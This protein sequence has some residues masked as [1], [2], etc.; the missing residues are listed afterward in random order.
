[1]HKTIYSPFFT[2]L[3]LHPTLLL[4]F[5]PHVL[6][7]SSSGQLVNLAHVGDTLSKRCR[8]SPN[9]RS[10]GGGVRMPLPFTVNERVTHPVRVVFLK[11]VIDEW[12][13]ITLMWFKNNIGREKK[14]VMCNLGEWHES[15]NQEVRDSQYNLQPQLG[16]DLWEASCCWGENRGLR[17]DVDKPD[18]DMW[19]LWRINPR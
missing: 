16:V 19:R 2:D 15:R 9:L 11:G 12:A 18:G 7:P 10:G 3:P 6:T 17:V 4:P 14:E 1:M 8:G 13:L 5:S